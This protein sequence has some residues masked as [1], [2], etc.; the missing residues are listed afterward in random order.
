MKKIFYI[1][2][3]VLIVIVIYSM[4]GSESGSDYLQEA[5]KKREEKIQYLASS[6]Q[7]PFQKFNKPFISPEY[8]PIQPEYRINATLERIQ[9]RQITIITTSTGSEEKYLKFAYA[10]FKIKGETLRLLILKPVGFGT[11]NN[12]FTA[13]SDKTSGNETYGGGRYLD[14]EI[15]KSDR[16]TI[17]FNQ[18]YNPYCAYTSEYACPLPPAENALPLKIEAGEKDYKH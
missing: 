3:P 6:E 5:K 7:S 14:L 10:K 17:D 11:M 16:I 12:Y 2:I 4:Q 9:E 18:A 8:F 15:G 13:F 1:I